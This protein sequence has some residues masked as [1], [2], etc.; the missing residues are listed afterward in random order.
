MAYFGRLNRCVLDGSDFVYHNQ[1]FYDQAVY[2]PNSNENPDITSMVDNLLSKFADNRYIYNNDGSTTY[3]SFVF[4]NMNRFTLD[5]NNVSSYKASKF[6]IT[7]SSI[8]LPN[9]NQTS[10]NSLYSDSVVSALK[11]KAKVRTLG[12][13]YHEYKTGYYR[14]ELV[15]DADMYLVVNYGYIASVMSVMISQVTVVPCYVEDSVRFE[16]TYYSN[17]N[18]VKWSNKSLTLDNVNVFQTIWKKLP[19]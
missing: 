18:E 8:R 13:I 12:P 9:G 7:V 5:H 4:S 15:V 2:N 17:S 10:T 11:D 6:P 1:G 16:T 19:M 14:N 3:N